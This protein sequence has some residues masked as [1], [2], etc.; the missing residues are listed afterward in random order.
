VVD[1]CKTFYDRNTLLY[2]IGFLYRQYVELALKE[3]ILLGN[4]VVAQP[5]PLPKRHDL[6]ELWSLCKKIARER[7]LPMSSADL[8]ELDGAIHELNAFDPTSENFRYP[9]DKRGAP[10]S[11]GRFRNLSIRGLAKAMD[12]LAAH[13]RNLDG[14][15]GAD[16]DLEEEFRSDL[17]PEA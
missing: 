4:K 9:V 12:R 2:P 15:L 1:G 3:F 17:Y 16:I 11:P 13:L 5:Y 7:R 8:A 6:G 10:S 14:L